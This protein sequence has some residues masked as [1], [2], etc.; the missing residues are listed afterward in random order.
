MPSPDATAGLAALALLLAACPTGPQPE[1][2]EPGPLVDAEDWARVTDPDT[3]DFADMRP[4]DA[5]CDDAGWYVD[6]FRRS[7][8]VQTEICDYLTLTQPTR[9]RLLPGD[10]VDVLGLHDV[11]TADVPAQGYLGLSL[12]GELVWELSV[13]IPANA[14]TIEESFTVERE[15]PEASEVQLHVHNHGP[16]TWE[17]VAIDVT[18][19]T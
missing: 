14:S 1:P 15:F 18:P 4:A 2:R 16:N 19:G 11:L 17:I 9:M 6:P 7:L 13:D 8:E 10:T 12:D 5:V 3:D